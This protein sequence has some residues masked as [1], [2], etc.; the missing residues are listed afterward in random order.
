MTTHMSSL[1]TMHMSS[2][3][4]HLLYKDLSMDD[5][6]NVTLMSHPEMTQMPQ[7]IYHLMIRGSIN[8]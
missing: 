1:D 5:I 6:S 8:E 7:W 2:W 3:I 4:Y